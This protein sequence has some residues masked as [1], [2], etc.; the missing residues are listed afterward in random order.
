M[1]SDYLPRNGSA[2]GIFAFPWDGSRNH[3]NGGG[4]GDHRKPVPD[5]TYTL[6][7]KLLKA[8]GDPANPGPLGDGHNGVVRH[9]PAITRP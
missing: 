3:D 2:T 9:R 1:E 6:T 4:N 8:L 7:V 5:G